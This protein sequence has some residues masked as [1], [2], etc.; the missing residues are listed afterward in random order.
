M[1]AESSSSDT[2]DSEEEIKAVPPKAKKRKGK[3]LNHDLGHTR[4]KILT[5][6]FFI[7]LLEDKV[8]D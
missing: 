7:I 3:K 6:R 2:S 1:S 8:I 4:G 5:S